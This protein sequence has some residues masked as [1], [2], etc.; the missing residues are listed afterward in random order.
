M[1]DIRSVAVIG[2]GVM[3]ASIAAHVAN[4]GVNVLL[5]DIVKP[6]EADRSALARG[7]IEK[8]KKMDPAPLMGSR[9]VK[10]ITPGNI[11][12]D[13]DAVGR[14]D[15]IV[16]AVVERLDVKQALYAKLD[17]VRKEGSVVSSNTSTIPLRELTAGM[18][19]GF[20]RDFCITHFFNPPRYMRLLEIVG[21]GGEAFVPLRAFLDE[22]LGKTVVQCN[23]TPGFIANRIGTYWVQCAMVLALDLGL[24]VEEADAVMGLSL[25][26]I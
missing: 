21:G 17:A 12:D 9:A 1:G 7:A 23:D 26:H 10:L 18:P 2:A 5:V 13:L 24:E 22:R 16:E 4:A 25:I 11:E 8:L 6:G 15:W 20:A 19:E 14:C 3:G